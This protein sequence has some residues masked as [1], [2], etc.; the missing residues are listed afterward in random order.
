M[1][2]AGVDEEDAPSSPPANTWKTQK[3]TSVSEEGNGLW[4]VA[5]FWWHCSI[6]KDPESG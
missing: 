2:V 3:E 5:A 4:P 1:L 6:R